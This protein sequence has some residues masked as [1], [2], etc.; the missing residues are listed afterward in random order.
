MS[1]A[2]RTG[3]DGTT[4]LMFGR[5]VF[6]WN[7][8]VEAYGTVDELNASLGVA[9][10]AVSDQ[11]SAEWLCSV[12]KRL[13]GLMGEL[14]VQR[15]DYPN[16]LSKGYA[17]IT[18]DDVTFLD[19]KIESLEKEEGLSFDGWATPGANPA[20]AA[21]DLARTVCRRAERRATEVDA[22]A[23]RN[24]LLLQFLNRLS[25]CLWLL[26]RKFENITGLPQ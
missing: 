5:R 4:G 14:A 21:L 11:D 26:A 25:D 24:P 18:R 1:I 20:A 13:V 3:D 6:K 7:P 12:Q 23:P 19:S 2:T 10:A 15:E 17:R 16:Y 22:D 9:R 8:Q